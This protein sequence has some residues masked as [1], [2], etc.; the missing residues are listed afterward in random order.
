MPRNVSTGAGWWS[1]AAFVLLFAASRLFGQTTVSEIST[2]LRNHDFSGALRQTQV[3]LASAP[4][5]PRLWTLQGIA[6]RGLDQTQAALAD[7]RHALKAAPSYLP[8]LEGAAQ[9]E[10]QTESKG[11][12]VIIE[13]LLA[14]QPSNQ[15]AHAMLA[16]LLYNKHQCEEAAQHFHAAA[17]AIATQPDALTEYGI[18]LGQLQKYQ[19]AT[20]IFTKALEVQP[21]NAG[22][23][24]NLAFSQWKAGQNETALQTLQPRLDSGAKDVPTLLLAADI[25]EAENNTPRAVELLRQAILA[26]PQQT[27]PY[28]QFAM[29]SYNHSSYQ[30]GIGMLNA[31]LAELPKSDRLYVARG[32]LYVQMADYSH[33]MEDFET[34]ERLNPAH[35]Q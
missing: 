32:V 3:A 8:A 23:R 31:G 5:D 2:S 28:L 10:Y 14:V 17:E 27:E 34:A 11:A 4:H 29:L 12:P 22:Y 35:R 20:P 30:A 16:V 18:C 15:T 7:F 25:L 6:H 1:L 9:I 33:A 26:N 19:E 13:R 24:Y 21:Q